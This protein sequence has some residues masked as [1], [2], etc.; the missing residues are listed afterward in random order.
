MYACIVEWL[1][2]EQ[3]QSLSTVP[4]LHYMVKHMQISDHY[5]NIWATQLS[6]IPHTQSE[7]H[8]TWFSGVK[9]EELPGQSLTSIPLNMFRMNWNTGCTPGLLTRPHTCACV[10]PEVAIIIPKTSPKSSG[11]PSQ[12]SGGY[13]NSKSGIRWSKSTFCCEGQEPLSV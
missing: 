4:L 7:V 6:R 10:I 11:K 9:G 8:N 13:Y 2:T 5:S 3:L 12:I 1:E